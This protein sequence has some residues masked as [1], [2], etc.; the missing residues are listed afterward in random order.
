MQQQNYLSINVIKITE[1]YDT[2]Y[3]LI[4]KLKK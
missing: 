2:T 1:F 3:T 4:V